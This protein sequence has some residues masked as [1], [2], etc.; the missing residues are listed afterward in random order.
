LI[1]SDLDIRQQAQALLGYLLK[2]EEDT[3]SPDKLR[4]KADAFL[5]QPDEGS[6]EVIGQ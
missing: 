1:H 6:E 3:E 4:E 5:K 2:A